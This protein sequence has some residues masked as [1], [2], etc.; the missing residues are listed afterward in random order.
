MQ[1]LLLL[2]NA[3][4]HE[5]L[6]ST[7]RSESVLDGADSD[8]TRDACILCVSTYV[9]PYTYKPCAPFLPEMHSSRAREIKSRNVS[10]VLCHCVYLC[11]MCLCAHVE[12]QS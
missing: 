8:G 4:N 2:V 3:S 11:V 12:T 1:R 6:T 5:W 7:A 9:C 10:H